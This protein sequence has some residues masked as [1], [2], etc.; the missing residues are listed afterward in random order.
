MI[1]SY[2]TKSDYLLMTKYNN[3][4]NAGGDGSNRL[5]VLDPNVTSVDPITGALVM[6]EVLTVTGATPDGARP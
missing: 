5:A 4:D 3:Y 1:R 2:K 6:K